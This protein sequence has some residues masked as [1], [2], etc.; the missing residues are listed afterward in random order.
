MKYNDILNPGCDRCGTKDIKG[1]T[2][3]CDA[4]TGDV[5]EVFCTPC[6]KVEILDDWSKD[7]RLHSDAT[8]IAALNCYDGRQPW[9]G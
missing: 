6:K 1:W 4:E 5:K 2:A 8:L 3:R 7:H 9:P